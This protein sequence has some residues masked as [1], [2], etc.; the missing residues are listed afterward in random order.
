MR[1]ESNA[2]MAAEATLERSRALSAMDAAIADDIRFTQIGLGRTTI[3]GLCGPQGSGKSTTTARLVERLTGMGFRVA[4]RSL[5]DFYL[6]KA[7]RLAL[8]REAHPLFATRG[9]P[10]T[11]DV[12]L[13]HDV[14]DRLSAAASGDS[15]PLPAFDKASDDRVAEADWPCFV[16]RPD[17]ILLEGWCVGARPQPASALVAPINSLEE[18]EDPDGSW[19]RSVNEHLGGVY[20]ALFSRLDRRY[21]L[22]APSFGSVF[23]WRTEQEAKLDR[24]ADQSRPAMAESELRR[25]IAHYERLTRWLMEDEPA[26]LIIDID[27]DRAPLQLR[28]NP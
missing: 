2:V 3:V 4:A 24:R 13:L 9:V 17:L 8:A 23:A 11:H 1:A 15:V 12:A 22:S 21:L 7:S 26:D 18:R 6:T 14:L 27:E 10:A 20:A 19:R 25:F 16:G 5:D 28:W